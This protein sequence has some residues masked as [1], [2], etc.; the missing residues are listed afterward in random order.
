MYANYA[1]FI[2]RAE[3]RIFAADQSLRPTPLDVV[4]VDPAGL[5][6][7]QPTAE[8]IA[9]PMRELKYVLRAYDENGAFDETKP[10]PL[11]LVYD[12]RR[13]KPMRPP[14]ETPKQEGEL[15]AGYGESGLS[16]SQHCARQRHGESARQR[17]PCASQ[18]VGG[19][20]AGSRR[21]HGNFIAEEILPAGLHTVEV[22]VL[23]EEGN[24]EL[25]LR[26]LEFERNDWFY[27]GHRGS[28]CLRDPHQRT[29]G[30]A[31]RRERA[32]S[33]YD[34]SFDGRLAFFVH[35]E[36]RR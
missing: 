19:G 8:Q 11:W 22:A 18:R 5:A 36:V 3:V 15:L 1:A 13:P 6:E 35:G 25:Y 10:Q 7:W 32:L 26:D 29:G 20:P 9:A 17:H 28:D 34:S 23:D 24:G 4:A 31:A 2:D 27:V 21:S 16:L 33:T 14:E 12:G 30:P